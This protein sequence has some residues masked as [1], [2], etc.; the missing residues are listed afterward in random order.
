MHFLRKSAAARGHSLLDSGL[1]QC[2]SAK[3]DT[4]KGTDLFAKGDRFI[5]LRQRGQIYLPA[6]KGTDLFA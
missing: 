6:P 4:P 2:Q 5:C 1:M 3:G